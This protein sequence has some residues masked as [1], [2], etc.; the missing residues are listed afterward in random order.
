MKKI[1]VLNIFFMGIILSSC[2]LLGE[3]ELSTEYSIFTS[4]EG[5]NVSL[6][7]GKS[8]GQTPIVLGFEQVKDHV[9][10][11]FVSFFIE[12]PGY[13]TRVI[14]IDVTKSVNVKID[15][16]VDKEYAL[17]REKEVITRNKYLEE[18]HKLFK[19][20]KN[21]LVDSIENYK[22]QLSLIQENNRLLEKKLHSAEYKVSLYQARD[23]EELKRLKQKN[24]VVIKDNEKDNIGS[25]ITKN[26]ASQFNLEIKKV[27]QE[28]NLCKK[29]LSL[30]QPNGAKVNRCPSAVKKYYSSGKNN[31]IIRELLTAQ[32]L[33]LNDQDDAAKEVIIKAEKGYPGVSAFYTLLAYIESSQGNTQKA[34]KYL[35][36]SLSLDRNDQMARRMLQAIEG[37]Q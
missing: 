30:K 1:R 23:N 16:G 24:K 15:L 22:K 8:L 26:L 36:K 29:T 34:K 33:L 28:L 11:R 25:L 14:F 2:S 21:F 18:K 32:F 3:K 31:R 13:F 10:G 12:K 35:K 5:A 27:N 37:K 17:K 19:D 7:D 9:D 4:V 6:T 20:Q